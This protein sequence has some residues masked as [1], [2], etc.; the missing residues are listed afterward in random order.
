MPGSCR[1]GYV[2]SSRLKAGP[3]QTAKAAKARPGHV[4]QCH[5]A[6]YCDLQHPQCGWVQCTAMGPGPPASQVEPGSNHANDDRRPGLD[7][8][9]ACCDADQACQ[10][11]GGRRDG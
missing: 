7:C 11:E 5:F 3:V 6:Y 4:L 2:L 10:G 8:C 9:A 1:G